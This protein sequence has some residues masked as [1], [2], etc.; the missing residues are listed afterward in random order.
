MKKSKFTLHLSLLVV[1]MTLSSL[2][3]AQ[4][5]TVSG[6]V[7]DATDGIGIPGVNVVVKG[8]SDGT[9]SDMNGNYAI[10]VDQGATLVFSFVGYATQEIEVG[11]QSTLNV[12]MSPDVQQLSEV[13][14]VGYGQQQ[15][16]DVT[17]VVEKVDAENFNRGPIVSPDQ[18]IA[19]KVAGVQITPNNGQPG[20]QS[21]IRIRGGTSINASNEPLFVIDGVPIQNDAFNPGG[22]SDGRNPLNFLNPDDI[23]SITVLKDASAAAIYGSRAANGVIMITTKRGSK[24]QDGQLTYSGNYSVSQMTNEFQ[25]LNAEQFQNVITAKAPQKLDQLGGANT[26]WMDAVLRTAHGQNHNLSYS[27]GFNNTG[28]RASVGYQGLEGVIK[29]SKTERLSLGLNLNSA[30]LDD[31]LTYNINFKGA[32]TRDQF[33][34][35]VIGDA[36]TFDPTQPI[37][38]PSSLETG[39]FFEFKNDQIAVDN[40]VSKIMQQEEFGD[41]YRSIGSFDLEYK[42]PFV[43]GLSAKVVA[44]FDITNGQRERFQPSTLEAQR[45][46]DNGELRFENMNRQNTLLDFM[47]KYKKDLEGISSTIDLTAGYSYQ[48]FDA[49]YKGSRAWDLETD[50]FGRYSANPASDHLSFVSI[51]QNRLISFFGRLNYSFKDRYLLTA[52]LRRDGSTRFGDLDKWGLFPS[53]AVAWRILEEPFAA[54]L[55]GIFSDLKLRAGYGVNGNQEIGNY[56]YLPTYTLSDNRARYQFGNE[57]ISVLRPNAYDAGL[58]WE[59]TTS[60]NIGLD[61]GFLEGRLN[62]SLEYY[63]KKTEDLLFEVGVPVGANLKNLVL[64]NIGSLS[65]QGVELSLNGI[66]M[67]KAAFRWSLSGNVAYNNNQILKLDNNEDPEFEG[68]TVGGISGGVGNNIQILREGWPVNSFYVY[69]HKMDENGNPRVDGIDYNEDGVTDLADM[70]EDTNGDGIVN[71]KDKDPFQSPDAD[72]IYGV[73]SNMNYKNFDFSFTLR[74]NVGNYVYNNNESNYGNFDRLTGNTANNIHAAALLYG[75]QRPQYFSDVYIQN[76]SFL[77]VDNITLGYSFNQIESARIRLYGTVQNAFN[78]TNY[79]GLDPIVE[80]GI[81]NNIYPRSRTFLIGLSIGL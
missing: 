28:F 62:G 79:R 39:G 49:E 38:D 81:D 19:G 68:Y 55:S 30:L 22:L 71:D 1:L 40:P 35:D 13:V 64:S 65:N 34:P 11:N 75:F 46:G 78:F 76:G 23:E 6:Q 48:D 4:D 31:A 57:Y 5:M 73:T 20:A 72:I 26:D 45:V 18:L 14:V 21:S 3:K 53:A 33:S 69:T 56:L 74:G 2:L 77:L 80:N 70:Y 63:Y 24:D 47:L 66:V 32:Y 8:T 37:Y 67:D 60:Y 27:G 61:Y 59:E 50:I 52:T 29:G 51:E 41:S 44:G 9:V 7:T 10:G 17:G 25:I 12:E 58:K 54:G 42:L 43:P 16:K 15:K 36:A